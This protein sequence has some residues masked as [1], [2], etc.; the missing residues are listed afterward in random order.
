M[1][2][3]PDYTVF[4]VF[5]PG[6]QA[7]LNFVERDGVN[8]QLVDALRTPG[9]QVIVYGETGSGKSTLLQN[10]LDQLYENHVTT[11]CHQSMS[12]D[13]I[14][15][16]A[17]DQLAPYYE[18]GGRYA[19]EQT[20]RSSLGADFRAIRA[21]LDMSAS[22][23]SET[24]LARVLPPQLTPQRLGQFL[25]SRKICW[26]IEDFH[27]V[28]DEVKTPLAQALKVFCDL[29]RDYREVKIVAIGATDTAHEV[30][31]YDP[32]MANRV[33]EIMVP[34]MSDSEVEE[35]LTGGEALLNVDFGRSKELVVA[36]SVGVASI[37]HQLALNMCTS[38]DVLLPAT[39]TVRFE[40]SDLQTGLKKY[41]QQQSDTLKS[42]FDRAL[43]RK[44]VKKY[45]NCRLILEALAT[46]PPSGML[47]GEI[48]A[49]IRE[50]H[51]Q[52]PAGNLTSYL[53]AL[54]EEDR[55]AVVRSLGANRYGFIDPFHQLY[56]H[57]TLS[58]A[59]T[60]SNVLQFGSALLDELTAEL[61]RSVDLLFQRL[62]SEAPGGRTSSR[63]IT[64][65]LPLFPS[66]DRPKRRPPTEP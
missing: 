30:I 20:T 18:E 56:C 6:T 52:Y 64:R 65:Q 62:S 13:Q 51:A 9:K 39:E 23:T 38:R 29:A 10:K 54:Q 58:D 21:S 47:H 40:A 11:R 25:G 27:K 3:G 5:T 16:D 63:S 59:A 1:A 28:A 31:E 2:S 49:K 19:I 46:A 41:I 45:D 37:C 35:I 32:E 34:L 15:L 4:D 24:S 66:E 43:V 8:E 7:R 48:L 53:R 22:T 61:E 36:Y 14:L 60:S 17:F 12:F 33:A 55:G 44:Q 50:R 57:L 42:R 26:V